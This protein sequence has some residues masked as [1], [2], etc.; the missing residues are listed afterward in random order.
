MA[1]GIACFDAT[2]RPGIDPGAGTT[3]ELFPNSC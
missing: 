2:P 1:S 3:L